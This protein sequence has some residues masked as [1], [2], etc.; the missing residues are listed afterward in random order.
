MILSG[1]VT[2]LGLLFSLLMGSALAWIGFE[3]CVRR[4]MRSLNHD[5]VTDDANCTRESAF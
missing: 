4:L 2:F 3:Y 1:I 5:A